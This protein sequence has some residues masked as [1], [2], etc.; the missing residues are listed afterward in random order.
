MLKKVWSK[1]PA[2]G[3]ELANDVIDRL[4]SKSFISSSNQ[5]NYDLI[6][7]HES[8]FADY[9]RERSPEEKSIA[10]AESGMRSLAGKLLSTYIE[11]GGM[12]GY[13]PLTSSNRSRT[14]LTRFH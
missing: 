7:S 3:N 13:I 2:A 11:R 6:K 14:F 8:I 1:D 5:V 9:L 10:F 12:I 4:I